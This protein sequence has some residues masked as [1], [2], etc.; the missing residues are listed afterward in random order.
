MELGKE[1][2]DGTSAFTLINRKQIGQKIDFQPSVLNKNF[3]AEN[4]K[5]VYGSLPNDLQHFLAVDRDSFSGT[6]NKSS[7]ASAPEHMSSPEKVQL[8]L[9]EEKTNPRCVML[10]YFDGNPE[11]EV[12]QHFDRALKKSSSASKGDCI[13]AAA[14]IVRL[15]WPSG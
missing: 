6:E 10:K 9:V 1:D 13:T 14:N 3:P 15:R 7:L 4:T 12:D 2:R 11:D 5:I 8:P